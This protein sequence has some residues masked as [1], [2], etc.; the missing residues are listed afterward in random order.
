MYVDGA[1]EEYM[2]PTSD[3]GRVPMADN[4]RHRPTSRRAR[5]VEGFSDSSITDS[6]S[7]PVRFPRQGSETQY[8]QGVPPQVFDHEP[9][10]YVHRMPSHESFHSPEPVP[11]PLDQGS[12]SVPPFVAPPGEVYMGDQPPVPPIHENV[13][14]YTQDPSVIHGVPRRVRARRGE[15]IT[16]GSMR[17]EVNGDGRHRSHRSRWSR[18]TGG[19]PL[20]PPSSG[21]TR[22]SHMGYIGRAPEVIC[23]LP[24]SS[25][26]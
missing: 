5:V 17:V 12:S 23:R 16:L 26:Q 21:V 6:D 19:D 22:E 10:Q 4:H 25:S 2:V 20:I 13:S 18:W 1:G 7:L 3:V 24:C 14:E 15:P 11:P 9:A 8:V